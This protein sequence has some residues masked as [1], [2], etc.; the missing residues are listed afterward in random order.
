MWLQFTFLQK[1]L[2]I[3][4]NYFLEK[5]I[6]FP[7]FFLQGDC[8]YLGKGGTFKRESKEKEQKMKTVYQKQQQQKSRERKLQGKIKVQNK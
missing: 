2:P 4:G 6:F 3:L 1:K 5:I 8:L 7:F